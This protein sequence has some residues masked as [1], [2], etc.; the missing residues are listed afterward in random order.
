[1]RKFFTIRE[2]IKQLEPKFESMNGVQTY[3][4][5]QSKKY[6]EFYFHILFIERLII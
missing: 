3:N 2:A 1:M 4:A 6:M 5:L